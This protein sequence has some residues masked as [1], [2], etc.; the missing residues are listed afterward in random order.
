MSTDSGTLSR[1]LLVQKRREALAGFR[2]DW[3]QSQSSPARNNYDLRR[4]MCF[5]FRSP[6]WNATM[7]VLDGWAQGAWS[8]STG[9]GSADKEDS[10]FVPV[11]LARPTTFLAYAP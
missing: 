1:T 9:R 6:G 5:S 3:A 10:D 8:W 7:H 4:V 2:T 11:P